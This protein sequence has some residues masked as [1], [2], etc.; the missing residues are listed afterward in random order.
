[1]GE[2]LADLVKR[3][4]LI[5]KKFT[6]V[7]FTG[8]VTGNQQGSVKNGKEEGA[9]AYY[10]SNG[11]LLAKGNYKNRKLEGVW[12]SYNEDGTVRKKYT[13]TFKNGKKI[14]DGVGNLNHSIPHRL[15]PTTPHQQRPNECT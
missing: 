10:F 12:I 4:G 1:M 8:K 9:W 15:T 2:T 5:Y 13:G 6:D 11:H 14:S 3:N 7:P